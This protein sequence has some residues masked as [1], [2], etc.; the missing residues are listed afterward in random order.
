MKTGD[1]VKLRYRLRGRP[2]LSRYPPGTVLKIIGRGTG[3]YDWLCITE[4]RRTI[5]VYEDD[6]ELCQ[7]ESQPV[8]RFKEGWR[9]RIFYIFDGKALILDPYVQHPDATCMPSMFELIEP[10]IIP[11]EWLKQLLSSEE[12]ENAKT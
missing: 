1:K 8:P 11:V 12:T 3:A 6:I 7:G 5:L 9:G 4:G 10:V 2:P